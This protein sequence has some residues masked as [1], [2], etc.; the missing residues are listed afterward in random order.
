MSYGNEVIIDLHNCNEFCLQPHN[1][2]SEQTIKNF[3]SDVCRV[4]GMKPVAL[5]IWK[6]HLVQESHLCGCSAV[7]FIEKRRY[8]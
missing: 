3:I 1:N 2:A 5:H 6:D 7:Q 4:S 8:L